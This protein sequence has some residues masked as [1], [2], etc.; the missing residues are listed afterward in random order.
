MRR[1][2]R[3]QVAGW[4]LLLLAIGAALWR[5]PGLLDRPEFRWPVIGGFAALLMVPR[6]AAMRRARADARAEVQP[7]APV[8]SLPVAPIATRAGFGLVMLGLV[9][10]IGLG[11]AFLSVPGLP[12]RLSE[13]K[14]RMLDALFGSTD[15]A[16]VVIAI[17]AAFVL[18]YGFH[19]IAGLLMGWAAASR[20]AG[21]L[22]I[23]VWL[24]LPF[25]GPLSAMAAD[26]GLGLPGLHELRG[27]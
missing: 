26:F 27:E 24:W 9:A 18:F 6:L 16:G 20:F 5:D 22:V 25:S 1:P 12:G 14:E 17:V 21:G 11:A 7:R 19:R 15:A 4:T 8:R 10:G 13:G 23:G 2:N 3:W